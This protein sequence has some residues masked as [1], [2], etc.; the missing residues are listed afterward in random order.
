MTRIE[1]QSKYGGTNPAL[2]NW[3]S[4]KQTNLN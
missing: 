4:M 3:Y 2:R 1:Q